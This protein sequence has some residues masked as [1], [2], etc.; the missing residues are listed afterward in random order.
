MLICKIYVL[1]WEDLWNTEGFPEFWFEWLFV[2][3]LIVGHYSGV[4]LLSCVVFSEDLVGDE[5]LIFPCF[6]GH[7]GIII[8]Y[9]N[10][11]G[12]REPIVFVSII[13]LSEDDFRTTSLVCP[14]VGTQCLCSVPFDIKIKERRSL[15]KVSFAHSRESN[16]GNVDF[17]HNRFFVGTRR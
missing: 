10:L 9:Q 7:L 16:G 1:Q 6:L 2:D 8:L 11:A 4:D 17:L 14:V 5:D 12:Q 15:V 3:K 13:Q